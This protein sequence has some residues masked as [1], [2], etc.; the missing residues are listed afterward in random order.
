M[1]SFSPQSTDIA[2]YM[3]E[4]WSQFTFLDI[5]IVAILLDSGPVKNTSDPYY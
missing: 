3:H 5:C 1:F 2:T 4:Q